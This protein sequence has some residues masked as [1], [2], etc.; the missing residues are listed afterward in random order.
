[1][2]LEKFNNDTKRK[3]IL[4]KL[5]DLHDNAVI[6]HQLDENIKIVA[7]YDKYSTI[8]INKL[9]RELS[10]Y[11]YNTYG[12]TSGSLGYFFTVNGKTFYN[13]IVVP[14]K[15]KSDE[16]DL[17]SLQENLKIALENENFEMCEKLK[18]RIDKLK[19]Q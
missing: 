1:M 14:P 10:D 6:S 12:I 19:K 8:Q 15:Y 5:I 18:T 2:D 17:E 4:Q 11:D 7:V 13:N 9:Y 16:D 3:A